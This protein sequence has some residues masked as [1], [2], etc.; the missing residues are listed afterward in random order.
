MTK[1]QQV[2]DTLNKTN[3]SKIQNHSVKLKET[4]INKLKEALQEYESTI[5]A[6]MLE[7]IFENKEPDP[8]TGGGFAEK[9]LNSF[10]VQEYAKE[11]VQ[12]GKL[13]LTKGIRNQ[14]LN[15]YQYK[16]QYDKK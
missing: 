6:N 7:P 13:D 9:T 16:G 12:N 5:L 15:K 10:L 14:L 11:I 8:L 4:Q 1:I 3:H 2:Y